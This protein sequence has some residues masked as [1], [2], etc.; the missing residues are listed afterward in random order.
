M[1]VEQRKQVQEDRGAERHERVYEIS[2]DRKS[3]RSKERR[4]ACNQ[5]N[6]ANIT[7]DNIADGNIRFILNDRH[8]RSDKLGQR[9]ADRN[10]G[11]PD[12]QLACSELDSNVFCAVYEEHAAPYDHAQTD[13]CKDNA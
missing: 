1:P 8:D 13:N 4:Y 7:S 2:L 9:G 10:D 12:H 11:K 6:I 3:E 5:E